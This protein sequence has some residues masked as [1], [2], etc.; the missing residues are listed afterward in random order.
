MRLITFSTG[1]RN[2]RQE[3]HLI[4]SMNASLYEQ[5][6]KNM[7]SDFRRF[8]GADMRLVVI[9]EGEQ[10]VREPSDSVVDVI[11]LRHPEHAKFVKFFGGLHEARGL[12]ITFTAENRVNLEWLYTMDA[13]RFAFKIFAIDQALENIPSNEMFGWIDA[14]V[15]CLKPFAATD[16]TDFFPDSHQ[17]MSYLGRDRFPPKHPYSECGFRK[18]VTTSI[19]SSRS[20]RLEKFFLFPSGMTAGS[21]TRP[22]GNSRRA[23]INSRIFQDRP[24]RSIT[25][26]SI[27]AWASFSTI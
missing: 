23:A 20:I 3:L 21:G 14:D 26:S 7:I 18:P 24:R 19:A 12:Q 5:Y 22:G 4:T 13:M 9:F 11:P 2:R 6:G 25:R 10:L 17:I 16:L 27:P 8:A 1:R 15:R